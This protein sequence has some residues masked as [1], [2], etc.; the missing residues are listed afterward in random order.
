MMMREV[1]KAEQGEPM[2]VE[3]EEGDEDE[4][5][6]GEPRVTISGRNKTD[7]DIIS[8]QRDMEAELARTVKGHKE[9]STGFQFETKTE[10]LDRP[11]TKKLQDLVEQCYK[12]REDHY[13]NMGKEAFFKQFAI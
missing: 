11:Q 3:T 5:L 8:V 9:A 1:S 13:D 6:E 2:E 7:I 4:G 10:V 12:N